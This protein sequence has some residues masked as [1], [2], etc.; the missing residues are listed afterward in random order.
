[1][2]FFLLI[3]SQPIV[4]KL[5]MIKAKNTNSGFLAKVGDQLN[6]QDV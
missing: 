5:E 1:M 4:N 3:K 2:K 6:K